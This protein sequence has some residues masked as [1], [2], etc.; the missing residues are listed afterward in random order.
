MTHRDE[1]LQ[2]ADFSTDNRLGRNVLG[3]LGRTGKLDSLFDPALWEGRS[4]QTLAS[5]LRCVPARFHADIKY[6]ERAAE[7]NRRVLD[8]LMMPRRKRGP[9]PGSGP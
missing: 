8:E 6:A 9:G 5:T 3:I 1:P 7:A 4:A 2:A